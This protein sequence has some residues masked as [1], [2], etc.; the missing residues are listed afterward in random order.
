MNKID[1][2]SNYDRK[3]KATAK[4]ITKAHYIALKQ[5]KGYSK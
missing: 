2:K 4:A 5:A 1:R 3:A